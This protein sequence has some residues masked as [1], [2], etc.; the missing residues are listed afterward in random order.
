MY[1]DKTK[2]TLTTAILVVTRY[3]KAMLLANALSTD[4]R[5]ITNRYGKHKFSSPP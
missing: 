3:N 1:C 4:C 2:I 5:G